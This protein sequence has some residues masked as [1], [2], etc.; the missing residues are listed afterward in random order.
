MEDP[1][2]DALKDEFLEY[3]RELPVI[4]YGAGYVGRDEATLHRWLDEDVNFAS[5]VTKAKSDWAK[6]HAKRVDSKFQLERLEKEIWSQ[7]IENTGKDGEPLQILS[8]PEDIQKGVQA[9]IQ[10]N[11]DKHEWVRSL[12]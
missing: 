7:R 2:V 3:Y 8:A 4:K 9:W 10:A 5:Q 6:K 11:P 12:L 1:T